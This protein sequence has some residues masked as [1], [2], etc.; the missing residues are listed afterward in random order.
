[1]RRGFLSWLM[2]CVACLFSSPGYA[3]AVTDWNAI[4]GKAAVAAC[5][6]PFDDPLHESRLYA[7]MHVAIHDAVN[8]IDLRYRPYV[9]RSPEVRSAS[10]GAA[11]ATAA[12]DVLV[13][14]I[15]QIP[16][17]FTPEC[18]AEGVVIVE[19]AYVAAL[20][21]AS[22]SAAEKTKGIEIGRSAAAAILAL[23]ANDGS[24]TTLLD[25]S[26]PSGKEPGE[27]RFTPPFTFAFAPKWGD[28][29]PFVLNH[30][31]QFPPPP[32]Y[33]L[34]TRKYAE[35]FAE[36]KRLG[37]DGVTTRSDRTK[38]ET[39][40][41]LFWVESSPL[42]WNRMGR[43]VSAS[44][45]LDLWENARLFGLLNMAMADGYISSWNAKFRFNF[46]RPITAIQMADIDG[47]PNTEADPTWTPL[48]PTPPIPDH[49]SGHSVQGGAAAEV[50]RRVFGTD[51]ISFSMCS[52]S[53]PPGSTC[54]D[55]SPVVRHY[56]SFTAA[57]KENGRSRVLVGFHF[58][59][60]V[61]EGIQHGRR[62][63]TRAVNLFFTPAR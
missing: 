59:N 32:P 21:A 48:L 2:I 17:P 37:G 8:S 38:T 18:R 4:A 53:M 51:N 61:E 14:L 9:F 39:E 19:A 36:V 16:E 3:D 44:Q 46:W 26:Y 29:T 24:D 13:S 52:H 27:Y 56:G 5:I 42:L 1:M 35:D 34:H 6:S 15:N 62:I 20:Q 63:A 7:M 30:P 23:R 54:N 45:G 10:T 28:V 60:A 50:F 40:T 41:A 43:T 49:D 11:V 31:G 12:R 22:G 58:S 47:N 33:N 55:A 25:F 57:E